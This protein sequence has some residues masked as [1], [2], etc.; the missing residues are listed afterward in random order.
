MAVPAASVP[1]LQCLEEVFTPLRCVPNDIRHF[2]KP[3]HHRAILEHL[4]RVPIGLNRNANW[5]GPALRDAHSAHA[6]D[7][8]TRNVEH[9]ARRD[10]GP[11]TVR[12]DPVNQ[13]VTVFGQELI[14]HSARQERVQPN[15]IAALIA[16]D[17]SERVAP[18]LQVSDHRFNECERRRVGVGAAK[19]QVV[20]RVF[21]CRSLVLLV[22]PF[23]NVPGKD[24]RILGKDRN[25]GKERGL[26]Q[27][28]V[29]ID[30]DTGRAVARAEHAVVGVGRFGMPDRALNRR[31]WR[32]YSVE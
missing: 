17:I 28:R 27:R 31:A 14:G 1:I 13:F 15:G 11:A 6:V 30:G 21:L 4:G 20:R 32:Q 25:A 10:V 16:L 9:I 2:D 22:N 23:P 8:V 24:R 3:A 29:F 26:I 12:I 7:A 5:I 19:Q 18:G